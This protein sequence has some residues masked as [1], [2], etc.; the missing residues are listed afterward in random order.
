MYKGFSGEQEGLEK[1]CFSSEILDI[2]GGIN[3]FALWKERRIII[4]HL[5]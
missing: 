3:I 4:P 1:M 5:N 2:I